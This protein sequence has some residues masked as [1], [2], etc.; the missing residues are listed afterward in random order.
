MDDEVFPEI[1]KINL[2]EMLL[3]PSKQGRIREHRMLLRV[4]HQILKKYIE[5]RVW[6]GGLLQIPSI[7][8]AIGKN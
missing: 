3:Q 2:L 7:G 8:K 5:R 1:I 4:Y 6:G